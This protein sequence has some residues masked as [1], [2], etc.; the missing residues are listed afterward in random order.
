M[1]RD[2][3]LAAFVAL[4]SLTSVLAIEDNDAP[5]T[6]PDTICGAITSSATSG[7]SITIEAYTNAS[8]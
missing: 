4:T 7:T 3:N 1:R 2:V 8:F 5:A 6:P